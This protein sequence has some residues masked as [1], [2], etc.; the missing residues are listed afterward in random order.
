MSVPFGC[1]CENSQTASVVLLGFWCGICFILIIGRECV[2]P[3]G[4]Q[5]H[6]LNEES[7]EA[8]AVAGRFRCVSHRISIYGQWG[9][10]DEHICAPYITDTLFI[11]TFTFS[12]CCQHLHHKCP[13]EPFSK[14]KGINNKDTIP[15]ECFFRCLIYLNCKCMWSVSRRSKVVLI[16]CVSSIS[17]LIKSQLLTVAQYLGAINS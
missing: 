5:K 7:R 6:L 9:V 4:S 15:C 14:Y 8:A 2:C 11:Q 10:F 13:G 16:H 3:T 17:Q 1:G 12:F